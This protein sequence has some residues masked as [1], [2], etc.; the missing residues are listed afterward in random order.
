LPPLGAA[1]LRD[2]VSFAREFANN[3]YARTVIFNRA[4]SRAVRTFGDS[5]ARLHCVSPSVIERMEKTAIA[6]VA[7][8]MR[9]LPL[10]LDV[11]IS[12]YRPFMSASCWEV[13][14]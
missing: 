2:V 4:L 14:E 10:C 11:V 7:H 5:L 6:G 3:S 13:S 1:R 8:P 12:D 9:C